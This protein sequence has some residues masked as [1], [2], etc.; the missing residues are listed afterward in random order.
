MVDAVRIR[1]NCQYIKYLLR[2]VRRKVIPARGSVARPDP[3]VVAVRSAYAL[4]P[5]FTK[6]STKTGENLKTGCDNLAA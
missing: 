5:I 3:S 2:P 4:G 6:S 1:V